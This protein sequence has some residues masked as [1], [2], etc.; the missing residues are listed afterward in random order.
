[1]IRRFHPTFP[2]FAFVRHCSSSHIYNSSEALLLQ[3]QQLY[4]HHQKN[5]LSSSSFHE[6][7]EQAEIDLQIPIVRGLR[8]IL[9]QSSSLKNKQSSEQE[10][11]EE[12]ST[13]KTISLV[14][15]AVLA[16]PSSCDCGNV[17][18]CPPLLKFTGVNSALHLLI[19][20]PIQHQQQQ[21]EENEKENVDFEN[22]NKNSTTA[23]VMKGLLKGCAEQNALGAFAASGNHFEQVRGIVI[24]SL[25]LD[26]KTMM[27]T[28]T[29][30][31]MCGSCSSSCC[32]TTTKV[33]TSEESYCFPCSACR[34]Y[35]SKVHKF[36]SMRHPHHQNLKLSCV[37]LKLEGNNN[38]CDLGKEEEK[39]SSSKK[40]KSTTTTVSLDCINGWNTSYKEVSLVV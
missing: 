4:H 10:L 17:C 13:T 29:G 24:C 31:E 19:H 15:S 40:K 5:K 11:K 35:L 25:H 8:K 26:L 27:T 38:S 16:T 14:S 6:F 33:S 1:M 37:S 34:N 32:T 20:Q 21:Q 18:S 39:S 28:T 22:N 12:T 7:Y 30:T 3:H 2:S 23:V 36:V 9:L